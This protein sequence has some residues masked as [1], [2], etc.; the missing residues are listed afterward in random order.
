MRILYTQ[1]FNRAYKK[2]PHKIRLLTED[3]V[4]IFKT[5]LFDPRLRTHKLHGALSD[6][7]AISIDSSIRAVFRFGAKGEI[8]F[9]F[10]GDH[11]VYE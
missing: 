11:S 4:E 9:H 8:I 3:K 10:I 7:W 6:Y 1:S 5:D 2:L